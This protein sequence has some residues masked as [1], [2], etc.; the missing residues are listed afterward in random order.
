MEKLLKILQ[1]IKPG[2]DFKGK[3]NLYESG[4]LDSMSII[5]L[6][7]ELNEEFQVEIQVTD[8]IPE[9][10]DSAES[11]MDMIERLQQEDV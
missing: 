3:T 8:L 1:E 5:M 9:N 2:V 6:T 11:M 7:S 10:F 4:I